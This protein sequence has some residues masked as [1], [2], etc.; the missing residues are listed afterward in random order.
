MTKSEAL[1]L[2]KKAI[3]DLPP[4]TLMQAICVLLAG[5]TPAVAPAAAPVAP[6]ASADDE[7][8]TRKAGKR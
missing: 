3:P 5:E 6:T 7:P 1:A 8:V 2:V 4:A